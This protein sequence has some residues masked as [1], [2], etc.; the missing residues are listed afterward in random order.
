M[1]VVRRSKSKCGATVRWLVGG[2]APLLLLLKRWLVCSFFVSQFDVRSY[3]EHVQADVIRRHD[4]AKLR[5][6]T[7]ATSVHGYI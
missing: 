2:V 4:V 6:A 5:C 3:A 1:V 7:F